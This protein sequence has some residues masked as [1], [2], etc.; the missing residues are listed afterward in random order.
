MALAVT[1]SFFTT[2][3]RGPALGRA[4]GDADAVPGADDG[5]ILTHALWA[6]RFSSD[7]GIVGRS[8]RMNGAPHEVVGVLAPDFELS[9]RDV[10]LLVPF[11]FTPEQMSDLERGNEF[12]EMIGRLRPGATIPQLNAQ[13]DAIVARLMGRVPRRADYMRNSGFTGVAVGMRDK[14][15]GKVSTSLYLLQAGVVLVLFIAC[16]NVGNLLLMRATGRH[17]EL[18]LRTTLGASGTRILRQLLTEGA[19]LSALGTAGGL[20]AC[21]RQ[22]GRGRHDARSDAARIEPSLH[23]GG[24]RSL[25]SS[26]S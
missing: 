25:S 10:S 18:A 14:I 16:A 23:P 7:P 19:L 11:A 5:V 6:S 26:R 22:P 9:W 13:M 3:R 2:L 20:A 24:A 15:V 12:S 21:R 4:F 17:R 8:I 1:P